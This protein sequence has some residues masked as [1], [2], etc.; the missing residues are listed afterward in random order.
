MQK[1]TISGTKARLSI[2][3]FSKRKPACAF[4]PP[5]V[6][7]QLCSQLHLTVKEAGTEL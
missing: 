6:Q 1:R 5:P 2:V 4:V 7:L 3:S